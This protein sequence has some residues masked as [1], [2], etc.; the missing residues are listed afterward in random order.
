MS[1]TKVKEVM[2]MILWSVLYVTTIL[3]IGFG[4]AASADHMIG[5][6]TVLL[7][8]GVVMF[9]YLNKEEL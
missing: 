3:A 9:I 1:I 2:K 8:Y 5:L 4:I 6:A 7:S